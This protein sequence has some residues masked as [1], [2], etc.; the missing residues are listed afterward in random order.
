MKLLPTSVAHHRA[1]SG[2]ARLADSVR[3]R[4]DAADARRQLRREL[5]SYT[6]PAEVN[7]LLALLAGSEDPMAEDIRS[8][9]TENPRRAA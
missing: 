7:D 1:A 9:L 6:T 3:A 8:I 2:A 5:S 4:R